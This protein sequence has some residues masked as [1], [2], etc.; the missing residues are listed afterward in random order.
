VPKYGRFENRELHEGMPL[1]I[2][3][4]LPDIH[5][6][7]L[8]KKLLQGDRC[9]IASRVAC[10]FEGPVFAYR[11][12]TRMAHRT[13]EGLQQFDVVTGGNQP[14][15][16]GFIKPVFQF[17][18]WWRI[19]PGPAQQPAWGCDCLLQGLAEYNVAREN[20]GLALGLTFAPH[21]AI[22]QRAAIT[23][24]GERGY[25]GMEGT[26]SGHQRVVVGWVE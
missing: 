14:F 22:G 6:L 21:I 18:G 11:H 2:A 20:G 12:G 19:T 24:A 7:I 8:P 9:S 16:Q 15:N 4:G 13:C 25:Q 3:T 26:L 17:Q 10:P 1:S 23:Q 5:L